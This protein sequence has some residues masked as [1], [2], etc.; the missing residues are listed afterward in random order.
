MAGSKH[1]YVVALSLSGIII[2]S[3]GVMLWG[4]LHPL[5][6]YL[7]TG[8]PCPPGDFCSASPPIYEQLQSPLLVWI[9]AFTAVV[10]AIGTISAVAL[11]WRSDRRDARE[12]ELRIKQL[13]LEL[14]TAKQTPAAL[15]P[16]KQGK[17]VH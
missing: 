15:T 14:E 1:G 6:H 17:K 3:I 7:P 5:R 2:L 8:L 9:P 10:S 11:A 12:K 13:E 16:K 4:Y